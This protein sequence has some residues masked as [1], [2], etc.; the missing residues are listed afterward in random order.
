MAR[1]QA[2]AGLSAADA[3]REIHRRKED[4]TTRIKAEIL[5]TT[6][7]N[8]P[9]RQVSR[10]PLCTASPRNPSLSTIPFPSS[11]ASAIHPHQTSDVLAVTA[12]TTVITV[13]VFVPRFIAATF[14][15]CLAERS[16][17][18]LLSL[19]FKQFIS[20]YLATCSPFGLQLTF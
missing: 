16:L 8:R 1:R 12:A 5:G 19:L 17:F 9:A 10:P 13:D 11:S 18:F 3:R 7:R 15:H 4:E 20:D 2:T 14:S 6:L